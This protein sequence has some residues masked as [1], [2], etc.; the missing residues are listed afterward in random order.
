MSSKR[1]MD[2]RA[3][4]T[5]PL[6]S[7]INPQKTWCL[8]YYAL[9]SFE[10]KWKSNWVRCFENGR[11]LELSRINGD[12]DDIGIIGRKSSYWSKKHENGGWDAIIVV[13]EPVRNILVGGPDEQY[14]KVSV[15][16]RPYQGGYRNFIDDTD[17]QTRPQGCLFTEIIYYCEHYS[18]MLEIGDDP[19]VTTIFLQKIVASH[20][21][22]LIKYVKSLLN[23]LSFRLSQR[24]KLGDLNTDWVEHGWS[25]LM[26]WNWRC[27]KYCQRVEAIMTSLGIDEDSRPLSTDN[28]SSCAKDF[29]GIHRHLVTLRQRSE[30]LASDFNGVATIVLNREALREA[31]RSLQEARSVRVLTL[32]G[33][34]FLSLSFVSSL[35]SMAKD[36]LP[37]AE[38]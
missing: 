23:H 30:T 7:L 19:L 29:I 2:H 8:D 32:L 12:L 31:N 36:Y 1:E 20:Y 34:L 10:Y 35:L 26:V 11:R 4:E 18:S 13:D 21:M 6:P 24:T 3:K 33:M 22:T 5:P 15:Q 28:M 17:G 16:S 25:D 14:E 38:K 27:N 37:G 9:R